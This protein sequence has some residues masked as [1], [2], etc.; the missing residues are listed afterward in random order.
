VSRC[1]CWNSQEAGRADAGE[2]P[3]A[4]HTQAA[5]LTPTVLAIVN[6]FL[7]ILSS[8][9]ISA[10]TEIGETAAGKVKVCVANVY[11]RS[12]VDALVPVTFIN[13]NLTVPAVVA[14]LTDTGVV[15][16]AV[17]KAGAVVDAGLE[18]AGVVWDV[19]DRSSPAGGTL[20]LEA[21]GQGNAAGI[22]LTGQRKTVIDTPLF[23]T[24]ES[25][26]V[27]ETETVID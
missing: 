9:T 7:A 6:I 8:E 19:A 18:V 2:G 24:P 26:R 23:K 21:H 27:G 22:V 14:G 25:L 12:V 11:A 16:G 10:L 5:V 13:V 4:I 1:L 17:T 3:D 15:L 20:A